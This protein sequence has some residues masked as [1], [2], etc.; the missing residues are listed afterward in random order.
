M[1]FL[2]TVA[3]MVVFTLGQ[4]PAEAREAVVQGNGGVNLRSGP[5]TSFELV[6]SAA[7]GARLPVLE[8]SGQWVKVRLADGKSG[9]VA[10]W[11]VEVGQVTQTAQPAAAPATTIPA[12]TAQVSRE[13]VAQKAVNLRSGPGTSF[14]LVGSAAPGARLPVLETSGQWVKVRLA[15]G[16]SGW[17]AGWLVE[18]RQVTQAAQPAPQQ[19]LPI[20]VT[21]VSREVMVK[22]GGVNIRSGPGT[23]HALAATLPQ[24]TRLPLLE[25]SGYWL[26]VSLPANKTGWVAAWLV[27]VKQVAT[28]PVPVATIP[29]EAVVNGSLVYIRNGPGT[30][31]NVV[32]QVSRGDRLGVLERSGDWYKVTAASGNIGWVAGWLVNVDRAQ[33]STPPEEQ[34]QPP[35]PEAPPLPPAPPPTT[36]LPP[37]NGDGGEGEATGPNAGDGITA[38]LNSLDIVEEFGRTV[39]TITGTDRLNANVFTL[40]A[41]D[42]LVIDISGAEPGQLPENMVVRTEVV[43]G[44]R[45]GLFNSEPAITRL[46]LDLTRPVFCEKK[47]SADGTTLQVDVYVPRLG[48]NLPGKVIVLDPGHG[49]RDPGATG[50]TGLQEKVVALDV[51]MQTARILRENGATVILTRENDTFVDLPDRVAFS[52]TAGADVFVSIHMNANPNRDKDG[53]STYFLRDSTGSHRTACD[54][55]ARLIQNELV[56]ELGRSDLGIMQANFAVLRTSAP[57]ALAEV[58]FISNHSEESLMRQDSFRSKSA[59]AIARAISNYFALQR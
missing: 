51:A 47:Y 7:P 46:V 58:A 40:K 5:G 23:S 41:P 45:S 48:E 30:T 55:L 18:V 42:R 57:A 3:L 39:V 28:A 29:V 34:V 24:G 56:D 20:P 59:E 13:A 52:E 14:E 25:V 54:R 36:P 38:K 49:G 17:V 43:T 53:T 10:G 6:G 12:A 8:T 11:L 4:A 2:V 26:K 15:D 50:P 37:I 33:A 9:W 35:T 31:H 22:T 16:K 32:S 19:A 21:Q 44:V 1:M 27:D